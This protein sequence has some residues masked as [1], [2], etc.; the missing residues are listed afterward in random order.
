MLKGLMSAQEARI[1]IERLQ[2]T[3]MLLHAHGP[4]MSVTFE[5]GDR[6]TAYDA[7]YVALAQALGAPL[8]TLDARL[9]RTA[10]S[11]CYVELIS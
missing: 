5:M 10:R 11:W 3:G 1:C 7:I 9:A 6:I 4:L 2:E 8:V